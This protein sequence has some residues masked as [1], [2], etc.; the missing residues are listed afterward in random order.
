MN[1]VITKDPELKKN[2]TTLRTLDTVQMILWTM[3][4]VLISVTFYRTV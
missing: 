1:S 2:D 3:N 4:V